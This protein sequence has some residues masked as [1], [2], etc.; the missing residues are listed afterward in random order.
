M[1]W[2]LQRARTDGRLR[3]RIHTLESMPGAQRLYE[4]MGFARLG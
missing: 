1:Q 2:C 4:R 3:L